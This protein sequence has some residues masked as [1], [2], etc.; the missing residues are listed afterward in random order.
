[1]PNKIQNPKSK[2]T[3]KKMA[4]SSL[5]GQFLLISMVA[6]GTLLMIVP[7]VHALECYKSVTKNAISAK[8]G[9]AAWEFN[10]M[11][12]IATGNANPWMMAIGDGN[13]IEKCGPESAYCSTLHCAKII[14]MLYLYHS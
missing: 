4:S 10:K 1:L 3:N 5:F 14:G 6:I 11:V 12:R 13:A 9:R 7:D 8:G 2:F